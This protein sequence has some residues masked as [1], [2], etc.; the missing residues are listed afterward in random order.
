MFPLRGDAFDLQTIGG[1][2][3]PRA[4]GGAGTRW[5]VIR[6]HYVLMPDEYFVFGYVFRVAT[7]VVDSSMTIGRYT[8]SG[9]TVQLLGRDGYLFATG[10]LWQ[11]GLFVKYTDFIGFDDETYIRSR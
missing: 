7:G 11:D 6:G 5:E 8:V 3:L 10:T 2:S 9:S 1:E 4:Y